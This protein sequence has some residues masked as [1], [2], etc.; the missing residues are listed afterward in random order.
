MAT[1]IPTYR[2]RF[3][4]WP[5]AHWAARRHGE[6][7]LQVGEHNY[8]WQQVHEMVECYSHGLMTQGIGRDAL[9][10]S[11]CHNCESQFWLALA[12][13]RIGARFIA[14]NP[15]FSDA[16][17]R[18]HLAQLK[19]RHLW[20]PEGENREF[21]GV[22][23]IT[24]A[25]CPVKTAQ[26]PIPVTWQLSRP[27][28][29]VLT[30]GS[31]GKP[32]AAVHSIEN[33]LASAAGLVSALPF[34]K[35]DSW[36]LSLPL[37]HVSGMAIIWRWLLKGACLVIPDSRDVLSELTRVTHASLVPTQLKQ[38]VANPPQT[39]TL[40]HVL[41]GG[42]AISTDLT[43]QAEALGIA[44]WVGY[45]MTEMASTVTLKRADGSPSVGRVLPFREL[46]LFNGTVFVRGATLC[47]GYYRHGVIF[48]AINPQGWFASRDLAEEDDGE[49]TIRGRLDN[50]FISGGENIQ[51]EEIEELLNQHPEVRQSFVLPIVH[52]LYGKRPVA[53]VQ[54]D[55]DVETLCLQQWLTDKLPSFKI[56]DAV[57][58][59][60]SSL[61]K[62]SV[63][64]SRAKLQE[65][66][67]EQNGERLQPL[68]EVLPSAVSDPAT[69]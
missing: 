17:V 50:M 27:V 10:A 33:H 22:T 43:T 49:I 19:I 2:D 31:T 32:K 55:G 52:D 7:A 14:L 46:Q 64:V 13:M 54:V 1:L 6:V 8:T 3:A 39:Q 53:V 34:E 45:G 29:L 37:Y 60:P 9:V 23:P 58:R 35:E 12:T 25:E 5:W 65:W 57:Y 21:V 69:K 38:V 63:K 16:E 47:L 67:N 66:L 42:A 51:P 48:P 68:N 56:P 36:L 15:R 62:A 30:S 26:S 20:Q 59:L 18:H 40:K 11:L 44:C 28:T 24:L 41:L 4:Q 61:A